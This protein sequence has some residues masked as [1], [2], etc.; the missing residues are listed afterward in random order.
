MKKK[1]TII[2]FIVFSLIIILFQ[3]GI[4]IGDV[5]IGKQL[6]L[7]IKQNSNLSESS[8]FRKDYTADNLIVLNLWATWCKPCIE[9]MPLLNRVKRKYNNDKI[10]FLSM[11]IDTDSIKLVNFLNKNK[12]EFTDIT[13]DNLKY[14]NAILNTLENKKADEW[15]ASQSVPVT[16]L[17]KNKKIVFKID[18]TT[19]KQELIALIEKYK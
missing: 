4:Q 14:R 10:S 17:I 13:F 19:E 8:F 18:G 7:K 12:F 15:I 9:E 5:R 16:Y 1:S 6:D 3:F 11:S 2:L